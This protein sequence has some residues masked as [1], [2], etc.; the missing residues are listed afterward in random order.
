[1]RQTQTNGQTAVSY[2]LVKSPIGEL[3]LIANPTD[4]I[5]VYFVD[6]DHAPAAT[7]GWRH[8]ARHEV[9]RLAERQ[10]HEYFAA[11]RETFRLPLRPAGT[12]FQQAVWR[13]IARI[14]YGKT[15]TYTELAKRS[16]APLAIRATGTSTGRNPLS[17][18][19]PCHRVMG[20]NGGM[21]GF[22]GGLERK[23]HLLALEMS[24]KK[25]GR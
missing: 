22:A 7:D 6:C 5:G 18:I 19:I 12:D 11:K 20:K 16:G 2:S 15:I 13:Q 21:C 24:G 3:I 23:G 14:P 4:L 10:L 8:D 25:S 17:I 9:L 1:M